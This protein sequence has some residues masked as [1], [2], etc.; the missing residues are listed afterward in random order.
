MAIGLHRGK[1]SPFTARPDGMGDFQKILPIRAA[2]VM[3][4]IAD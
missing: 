3:P 4:G 2:L 1:P